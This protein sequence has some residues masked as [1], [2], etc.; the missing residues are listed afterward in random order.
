MRLQVGSPFEHYLSRSGP[1]A[2]L[3]EFF[4]SFVVMWFA[5]LPGSGPVRKCL[6]P[7]C[8]FFAGPLSPSS[9][10]GDSYSKPQ[11]TI[12]ERNG[13]FSPTIARSEYLGIRRFG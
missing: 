11:V 9:S 8:G 6:P 1:L 12:N 10:W 5:T 2:H 7:F 3:Y 4:M 13:D